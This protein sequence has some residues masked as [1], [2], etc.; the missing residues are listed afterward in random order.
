MSEFINKIFQ[1]LRMMPLLHR[2]DRIRARF[3]QAMEDGYVDSLRR[4]G[5]H[6]EAEKAD[7]AFIMNGQKEREQYLSIVQNVQSETPHGFFAAGVMAAPEDS[8]NSGCGRGGQQWAGHA[9]ERKAR[10]EERRRYAKQNGEQL[11]FSSPERREKLAALDSAHSP[12]DYQ[13]SVRGR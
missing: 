5:L 8:P 1:E 3:I 10:S 12:Y 13:E 9:A 4:E 2:D 6:E 11:G 7:A